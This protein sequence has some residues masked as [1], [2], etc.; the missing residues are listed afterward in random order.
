MKTTILIALLVSLTLAVCKAD[1]INSPAT[2]SGESL[3]DA[4]LRINKE[5]QRDYGILQPTPITVSKLK[6]AIEFAADEVAV[7][8]FQ[9]RAA[10]VETLR[11]I[12]ATG[13]IPKAVH[14]C[15]SP[16]T[17]PYNQVNQTENRDGRHVGISL[18]YTLLV[19]SEH[20]NRLI[21]LTQIVEVFQI[22][23]PQE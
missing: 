6:K 1:S 17:C 15:F 9:G 21:G 14:F 22:L 16:I 18:N 2:E 20:G 12:V 8:D 4:V 19:L 7:S 11:Q 10:Y 13:H 23:K 3:T 5:V